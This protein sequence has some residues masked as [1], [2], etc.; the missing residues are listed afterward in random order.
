MQTQLQAYFKQYY[1][2]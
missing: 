1:L 2:L